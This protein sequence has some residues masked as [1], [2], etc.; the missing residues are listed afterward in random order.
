MCNLERKKLKKQKK[1]RI[2]NMYFILYQKVCSDNRI[3]ICC[4]ASK[5]TNLCALLIN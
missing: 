5:L 2:G 4:F 3:K 1:S